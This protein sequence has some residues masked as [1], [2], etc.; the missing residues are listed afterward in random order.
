MTNRYTPTQ[1]ISCLFVD[2]IAIG[3]L[4]A[5]PFWR[6][7]FS[8]AY[9]LLISVGILAIPNFALF[10]GTSIKPILVELFWPSSS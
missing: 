9:I 4:P 10:F 8:L 2:I 7:G 1:V 3:I 5:T 6:I